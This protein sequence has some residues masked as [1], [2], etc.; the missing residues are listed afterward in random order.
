MSSTRD[1]VLSVACYEYE[2]NAMD[3]AADE[4]GLQRSVFVRTIM[5]TVIEAAGLGEFHENGHKETLPDEVQQIAQQ[6]GQDLDADWFT[7]RI[8]GIVTAATRDGEGAIDVEELVERTGA[9]EAA[10]RQSLWELE[11]EGRVRI[12][13]DTAVLLDGA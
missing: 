9:H 10:V 8:W 3:R 4:C 13:S 2:R 6:I 12:D 1:K 5:G 7:R 11:A